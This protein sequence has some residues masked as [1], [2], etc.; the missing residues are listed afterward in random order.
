LF[1]GV[2]RVSPVL[3]V[4]LPAVALASTGFVDVLVVV[5]IEIVVV[6]DGHIAV[7]PISIAP[8][9]VGPCA[10]HGDG[11][12]PSQRSPRLVSGIGVRIVG[13]FGGRSPVDYLRVV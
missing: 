4:M 5:L 13:I 10:T 8:F 2:R 7:I 1:I 12:S 6:V 9:V 3:R 11:R